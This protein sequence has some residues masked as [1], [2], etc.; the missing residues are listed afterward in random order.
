[1]MPQE[2]PT[3]IQLRETPACRLWIDGVGCWLLWGGSELLFGNA[4]RAAE[5]EFRYRIMGALAA[6]HG[7]WKRRDGADWFEP[8]GEVSLNE[9]PMRGE[10]Q[11]R[12]NDCIRLGSDVDLTIKVP[13]PLSDTSTITVQS[14]HR[15]P[16][17][18]SGV[19]LFNGLCL[20]GPDTKCH[21]QCSSFSER[22]LFYESKGVL[23]WK[24]ESEG[25]RP[26]S[27]AHGDVIETDSGCIRVELL[28]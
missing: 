1:M 24:S 23:M 16:D 7:R 18:L 20:L 25:S 26:R 22:I 2:D 28:S 27:I 14:S 21:I 4:N 13:S 6:E 19:V 11:L 9:A 12:S 3:A 17:S 10:T 5:E 15:N 8:I